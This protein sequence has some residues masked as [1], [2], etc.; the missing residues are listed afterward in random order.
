MAETFPLEQIA[1]AQKSFIEKRHVGKIVLIPPPLS[2]E[3]KALFDI[4]A[5]LPMEEPD[6]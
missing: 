4:A 3:Q 6:S 2:R 5:A 1:E